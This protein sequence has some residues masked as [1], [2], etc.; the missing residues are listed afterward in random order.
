MSEATLI[1]KKEVGTSG[2]KQ[3]TFG[4][5]TVATNTI[6]GIYTFTVEDSEFL[7]Q[8]L[9]IS[10]IS[11][12]FDFRLF[13]KDGVSSPTVNMVI[14]RNGND[15]LYSGNVLNL[16]YCNNDTVQGSDIYGQFDNNDVVNNTGTITCIFLIR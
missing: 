2:M 12:D 8:S 9:K 11:K 6:S 14:E 10:C 15:S 16:V 1:S 5:P 7:L 4:V 13:D 3:F